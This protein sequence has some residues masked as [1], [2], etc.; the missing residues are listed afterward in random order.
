MSI[1]KK[2]A[3]LSLTTSAKVHGYEIKR[4]PV[5]KFISALQLL[6]SVPLDLVKT[7]FATAD[8]GSVL[9]NLKNIGQNELIALIIKAVGVLPEKCI[10]I[11]ATLADLDKETLLNDDNLGLSGLMDLMTKWVEINGIVNFMQGAA[12][13]IDS[14]KQAKRSQVQNIGSNA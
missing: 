8:L 9:K 1:F 10:E 5:G 11:F 7:V 4:A 3:G 6:E 2:T 12:S 14:A 13:L